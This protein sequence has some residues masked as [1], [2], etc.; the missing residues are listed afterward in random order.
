MLAGTPDYLLLIEIPKAVD[1]SH[2]L[3]TQKN[4][5]PGPELKMRLGAI[6]PALG[7]VSPCFTSESSQTVQIQLS[8]LSLK[9]LE[10]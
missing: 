7:D 4:T 6:S 5:V 2:G 9:N 1:S 3:V 10:T 8:F